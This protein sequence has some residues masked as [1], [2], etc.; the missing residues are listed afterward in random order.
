MEAYEIKRDVVFSNADATFHRKSRPRN[1]FLDQPFVDKTV[2]L[3]TLAVIPVKDRTVSQRIPQDVSSK[4]RVIYSDF[5]IFRHQPINQNSFM[6]TSFRDKPLVKDAIPKNRKIRGERAILRDNPF[7]G[8]SFTSE[9]IFEGASTYRN[10]V[11]FKEQLLATGTPFKNLFRGQLSL[12]EPAPFQKQETFLEYPSTSN[13]I[14]FYRNV[15]PMDSYKDMPTAFDGKYTKC[16]ELH[17]GCFTQ[18]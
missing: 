16:G 8:Q 15:K 1:F 2:G 5:S 6:I 12:A 14:K 11:P 7:E 10:Q 13:S 17:H 18:F 9:E 4:D 3:K